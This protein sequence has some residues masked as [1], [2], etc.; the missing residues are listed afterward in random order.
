LIDDDSDWIV[1]G[2]KPE[3]ISP[4]FG[5]NIKVV[6]Y[7][8]YAALQEK[9]AELEADHKAMR[10]ALEFYVRE[11]LGVVAVACLEGLRVK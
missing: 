11:G 2:P 4:D 10:E 3:D 7:S 1:D 8:A 9:C 6:E 5:L